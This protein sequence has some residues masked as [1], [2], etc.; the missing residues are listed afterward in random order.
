MDIE[1][2]VNLLKKMQLF[3]SLGE[4]QLAQIAGQLQ[5]LKL[6][7]GEQLFSQ[8]DPGDN[9]YLI[10]AGRVSVQQSVQQQVVELARLETGD[11]FGEEALIYQRRRSATISALEDC[12]CLFWDN[13]DFSW[14]I[15]SYPEVAGTLQM[16]AASREE[17]RQIRFNWLGKDEVIYLL[18]RRHPARF[19]IGLLKPFSMLVVALL[20]LV[21]MGMATTPAAELFS[22]VIGSVLLLASVIWTGWD[23]IDWRNDFFIVTNQRV[24]WLEQILFR[25]ASSQEAPLTSIQS[26]NIQTNLIGRAFD[27]GNLIVRTFTG[28]LVMTDVPN[29]GRMQA[30]IEEL[31][32]RIRQKSSQANLENIRYS[33]RNSLGYA[34]EGEMMSAVPVTVPTP[35]RE[36]GEARP[37]ILKTRVIE[38]ETYT[39]Y[40]HWY[41][42]LSHTWAPL[43]LTVILTAGIG[44][45]VWQGMAATASG[46][47]PLETILPVGLLALL[48]PAGMVVYQYLDW[49]NDIYQVTKDSII[50]SEKKPFGTEITKSAPLKNVLSLEHKR[51]GLIGLILNYGKVNIKIGDTTLTFMGVH[52]PAQVQQDIFYRM[53]KLKEAEDA[54]KT[55]EERLRML[56]WLKTYHEIR[57]EEG[58]PP[59]GPKDSG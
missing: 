41:V 40:K 30:M 18:A 32:L 14:I 29:P 5:E 27:F 36:S 2:R 25:S 24:V 55:E 21:Y 46:G 20:F 48:F 59:Q 43:L 51:Q 19:W 50:D 37:G 4:E 6:A 45:L 52:D 56:D 35:A 33:I 49:R 54:A 23:F 17:L 7:A 13:A 31:I 1:Q 22:M 11:Y 10:G 28:S 9:F 12:L 38:G 34:E 26:M 57:E 53:Q 15:Q 16:M 47:L 44:W 3:R 8:G 42:L 39:Y 58:N